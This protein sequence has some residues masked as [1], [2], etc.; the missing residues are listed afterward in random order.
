[1]RI[2]AVLG[3]GGEEGGL[4]GEDLAKEGHEGRD[5]ALEVVVLAHVSARERPHRLAQARVAQ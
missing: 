2:G 5:G 1:M 4:A 3:Q